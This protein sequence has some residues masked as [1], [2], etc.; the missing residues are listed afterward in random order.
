MA[1]SAQYVGIPKIDSG[2]AITADTSRTAPSNSAIAVAYTSGST[3]SRID[4]IHIVG[5][6]TTVQSQLR[7]WVC[8]GDVGRTILTITSAT[9]TAT[10]TTASAHNLITG[11]L[12]TIQGAFPNEY[13]VK[14]VAITV[15]TT[16]AFTFTIV[17]TS[18]VA[19]S[20][21]G[22][23]STTRAAASYSLLREIPIYAVTPSASISA[24]SVDYTTAYNGDILP[25]ILPGGYSVRASVNDAQPG[26]Q[27]TCLGGDF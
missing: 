14:S 16:T 24:F 17:S 8:K 7:L 6:G 23:Y 4:S 21:L 13:N 3:G 12:V 11:D 25:I 9:T 15:T 10:C 18:G 20:T 19:A 5:L 26:V 22:S 27:V 1:S 2:I